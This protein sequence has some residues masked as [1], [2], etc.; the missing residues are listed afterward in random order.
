MKAI[1]E[2]NH[3]PFIDAYNEC[4]INKYTY[5]EYLTSEGVYLNDTG[6]SMIAEKIQDG[7]S[8]YY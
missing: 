7:F 5:K 3:I 6:H 2:K 4:M 8:R 1:A